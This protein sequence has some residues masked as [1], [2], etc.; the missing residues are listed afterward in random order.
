MPKAQTTLSVDDGATQTEVPA[1]PHLL[2]ALE[3]GRPSGGAGRH[4]LAGISRVEIGRGDERAVRRGPGDGG[5]E[6]DI[7]IPDPWMS[8]RHARLER[9]FGRWIIVD[10]GSKNGTRVR[11]EASPRAVLADGDW[12]ELGRTFFRFREALPQDGPAD[13]ELAP[14]ADSRADAAARAM[15]TIDPHFEAALADLWRVARTEIAVLL[16]GES[17]TGKEV[18]AR[19]VHELAGSRG[20]F[21][22]VNCGAIP[23]ELVESALFGHRKGAF[24]GAVSE[25]LG[26]VRSAH[27]GTLFLDEIGDLR[28]SS[29][30]A[31]L[32]VL[33]EREVTPVGASRPIRVDFRLVSATH[34]DLEAQVET[35]AFRRDLFARIAGYRSR[36]PP[37]R[38]RRDDLG[39]LVGRFLC[40]AGGQNHPGLEPDAARAL[41]A[42]DWP[43]NIRE[44]ETSLAAA[45]A[46]AGS[47][48]ITLGHLPHSVRAG[49]GAAG[50]DREGAR[51]SAS[52]PADARVRAEVV[53]ALREAGGNISA[54][55]R[56][57]GKDRKQLQR[58][59]KR[60]D[61]DPAS[62]HDRTGA[63]GDG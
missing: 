40:R 37:L 62:F 63:R 16:D 54:A 47:A 42:C 13:R 43:L 55:A 34:R 51:A 20:P 44:L 46:L 33:Q 24:S 4:C 6:L 56:A 50:S 59:I 49:A 21:V 29:Q 3:A 9:S 2:V 18:L 5:A 12:I 17:G 36:L 11:G 28:L 32:R 38:E 14:F 41:L 19:A 52:S 35:G 31:L 61:L 58:W 10:A 39:H 48:P 22:P 57:L 15:E 30:A 8:S 25:H 53:A 27:G 1:A 23:E 45:T 26:F 7:R 60:F